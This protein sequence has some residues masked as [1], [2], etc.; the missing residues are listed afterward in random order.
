VCVDG[1]VVYKEAKEGEEENGRVDFGGDMFHPLFIINLI[2][3]MV[4]IEAI[5]R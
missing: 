3:N 4:N 2:R 1:L 5:S